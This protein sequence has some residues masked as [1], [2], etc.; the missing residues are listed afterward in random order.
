MQALAA[1]DTG[2]ANMANGNVVPWI[3]ERGNRHGVRAGY[4]AERRELKPLVKRCHWPLIYAITAKI[5][6]PV[7]YVG[8]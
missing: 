6:K 8:Q 7:E 1:M 4:R 3:R 5:A 2:V